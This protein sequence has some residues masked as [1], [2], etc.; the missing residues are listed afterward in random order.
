MYVPLE[1]LHI[2]IVIL[3]LEVQKQ[4]VMLVEKLKLTSKLLLDMRVGFMVIGKKTGF[5]INRA[6]RFCC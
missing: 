2:A 3:F 1:G 5:V 4:I 6:S